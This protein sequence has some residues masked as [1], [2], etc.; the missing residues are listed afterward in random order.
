MYGSEKVNGSE[1]QIRIM[2]PNSDPKHG[3]DRNP[4]P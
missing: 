2:G 3:S 1:V 4:D